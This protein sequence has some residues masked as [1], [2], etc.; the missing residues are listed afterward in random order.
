MKPFYY[1]NKKEKEEID[2]IDLFEYAFDYK[3]DYENLKKGL[4]IIKK[5][6]NI[7]EK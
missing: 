5:H 4:E 2:L 6:V 1:I 7:S 3:V